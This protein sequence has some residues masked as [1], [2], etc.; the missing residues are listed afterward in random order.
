MKRIA[1]VI[2]FLVFVPAAVAGQT[3]AENQAAAQTEAARLQTLAQLPPAATP[4]A[5]EP[6][7]DGNYL[8]GTIRPATPNLVDAPTW[9]VVSGMTTAAVYAYVQ[10]HVPAGAKL[11][12]SAAGANVSW[13]VFSFPPVAGT[14]TERELVI[15]VAPLQNGSVG[16]RADGQAVWQVPRPVAEHIRAHAAHFLRVSITGSSHQRPF[17]ISSQSRIDALVT[18]LNS[19]EAAQP[20]AVVCPRQVNTV[21]LTLSTRAGGGQVAV[22]AFDTIGCSPVRLTLAG[23]AQPALESESD[24]VEHVSR[25]LGVTIAV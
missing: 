18:L 6:A 3:A 16:V 14:L 19:L 22:A 2:V 5:T 21:H 23:H 12:E 20:F 7:G 9:W 1:A 10:T 11:T 13:S 8:G 15:G 4:S 24:L 25:I 17:T